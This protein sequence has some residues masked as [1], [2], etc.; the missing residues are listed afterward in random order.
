MQALPDRYRAAL[1]KELDLIAS[2]E[3]GNLPPG[4]ICRQMAGENVLMDFCRTGSGAVS[5]TRVW[6]NP[7]REDLTVH[8]VLTAPRRVAITLHDLSG[9]FLTE[10]AGYRQQPAGAHQEKFALDREAVESGTYLVT[11]RTDQGEQGVQ[12]IVVE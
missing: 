12:R 2:V 1:E 8:Y 11:I 4:E 10:I 5:Y 7:A 9:R 6:P 3:E